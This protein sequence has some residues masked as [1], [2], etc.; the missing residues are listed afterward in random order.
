MLLFPGGGG[1]NV[2]FYSVDYIEELA[3]GHVGINHENA[4]SP[5]FL[6]FWSRQ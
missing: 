3:V 1:Q 4:Q 2:Q 6:L 5:Y